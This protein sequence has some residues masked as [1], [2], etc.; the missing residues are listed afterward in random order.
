MQN[1][2]E[3]A[4]GDCLFCKREIIGQSF[5]SSAKFSAIYNIAPVLPGHSLIIPNEHYESLLGLSDPDLGDMMIFARKVTLVLKTVFRCEAF[6]WSIQDGIAAGQTVPHVH[7]HI[8]PRKPLD[9]PEGNEWYRKI[10]S[11]EQQ[12]ADSQHRERLNKKEYDAIT[13]ML[14][15]ASLSHNA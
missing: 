9:M 8:V 6:D 3:Q 1:S 14:C 12:M 5:F 11:N 10:T 13:A 15:E 4:P 2:P 7:M